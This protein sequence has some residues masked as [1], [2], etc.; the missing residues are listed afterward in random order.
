MASS[1]ERMFSN[2]GNNVEVTPVYFEKLKRFDFS[3]T[4]YSQ[5]LIGWQN[6]EW[7]KTDGAHS[8]SHPFERKNDLD[9]FFRQALNCRSPIFYHKLSA[10]YWLITEVTFSQSSDVRQDRLGPVLTHSAVRT[11]S[12]LIVS[13]DIKGQTWMMVIFHLDVSCTIL[14]QEPWSL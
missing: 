9:S 10:W 14:W 3:Q 6:I 1:A 12:L 2:I 11:K 5:F 8:A 4:C 13:N 7:V